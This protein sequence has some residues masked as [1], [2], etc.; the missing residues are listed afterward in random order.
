MAG[1][2]KGTYKSSWFPL[3][4]EGLARNLCPAYAKASARGGQV[5]GQAPKWKALMK[6][7]QHNRQEKH[8]HYHGLSPQKNNDSAGSAQTPTQLYFLTASQFDF[9]IAVFCSAPNVPQNPTPPRPI[10]HEKAM[11]DIWQYPYGYLAISSGKVTISTFC[12]KGV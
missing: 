4:D 3:R 6:D 12:N 2:K 8:R 9:C 5:G 1:T 7:S 11:P 10:K